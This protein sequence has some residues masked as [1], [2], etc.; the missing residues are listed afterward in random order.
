MAGIAAAFK[1]PDSVSDETVLSCLGKIAAKLTN[2]GQCGADLLVFS[3]KT[4][5]TRYRS[6]CLPSKYIP[7]EQSEYAITISQPVSVG[8]A[9]I[10]NHVSV[11]SDPSDVQP[12]SNSEFD[13]NEK[14][15]FSAISLNG[16]LVN[17]H[18]LKDELQKH[19]VVLNRNDDAEIF[20]RFV[21]LICRRDYWKFG[22][23][24]NYERVFREIDLRIDGAVSVLLL[25]GHGN[26]VAYRNQGGIR[27][28]DF[29]NTTDK[30]VLFASENGAFIDFDGECEEVLPSHIKV[31][32]AQ[33]GLLTDHFVGAEKHPA[34]LCAFESIYIGSLET[35][36]KNQRH[37]STR[38]KIGS[39]LSE[40]MHQKIWYGQHSE[41][42]TISSM[43]D[44][45]RPYAD[46]LFSQLSKKYP[47]NYERVEVVRLNLS[48][49][50]L[51]GDVRQRKSLI[52]QKYQV[53][54]VRVSGR[55][56]VIVDEALIR[57]DT[58]KDVTQKLIDAGASSIHWVIGS[59]PIIAPNYYGVGIQHMEELAFWKV[60]RRLP[61]HI[62]QC[63]LSLQNMD[64][65]MIRII[66]QEIALFIKADSVTYLPLQSLI[67]V[68]P[69]GDSCN[70]LSPFTLRMPTQGGQRLAA[71][72]FLKIV[73]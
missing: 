21:E 1:L 15:T 66:E 52:N 57:A 59:P 38:Y 49:R 23:P 64:P 43:P 7:I 32:D 56:I 22:E 27:P 72:N 26:L 60:W 47:T 41:P 68:L 39:E 28:L 24:V 40:L 37:E 33:T 51:I 13:H 45:G 36:N 17:G 20:M 63:G 44:T 58:S 14:N 30:F 2:R 3:E 31:L 34:T 9:H 29:M 6:D 25:D 61:D 18:D 71:Q 42:I 19:G 67:E 69:G 70:D 10:H 5:T 50:T 12:R 54:D 8:L 46:G 48:K 4:G 55:T 16:A 65:S 35:K 62:K 53:I 73:G 11:Q